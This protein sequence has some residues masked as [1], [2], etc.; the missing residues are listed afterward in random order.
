MPDA[1]YQETVRSDEHLA[2]A[3]EAVSKSLVLLTNQND[4]L[5]LDKNVG[6]IFLTGSGADN[7]GMQTGGWTLE[8]QGVT[9]NNTE[10]T[11]IYTALQ[12]T[13]GVDTKLVYDPEGLFKDQKEKADTGIVVVGEEP[14][15]E[16]VGDS[17]KLLLSFKDVDA[18][19]EICRCN[20]VGL[21][22]RHGRRRR[23]RCAL[24]RS[25]VHR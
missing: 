14:Y 5:P 10:G 6:T 16:G 9:G 17:E 12:E 13:V 11:S 2:L 25:T 4:T 3:R 7:I 15:A 8:W 21:V 24:R 19:S 22:V 1:K 20:C 23:D 18:V